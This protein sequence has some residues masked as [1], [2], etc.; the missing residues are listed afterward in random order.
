MGIPNNENMSSD[1][2]SQNILE[3]QKSFVKTIS[4]IW[5][6][7]RPNGGLRSPGVDAI[8]DFRHKVGKTSLPP[9]PGLTSSFL[10]PHLD[11]VKLSFP[12]SF[13]PLLFSGARILSLKRKSPLS[14]IHDLIYIL[15]NTPHSLCFQAKK[16]HNCTRPWI[17]FC[18][19]EMC[20]AQPLDSPRIQLYL[21]ENL[22]CSWFLIIFL[23]TVIY[24]S[25]DFYVFLSFKLHR[26][27]WVYI[28][29]DA[30]ISS[31]LW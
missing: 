31:L 12:Y 13:Q 28:H 21:R 23:T 30:C 10:S 25:L 1:C 6:H 19:L 27:V 22:H 29:T 5:G 15:L 20:L 2:F 16:S 9:S 18:C 26:C 4:E 3:T 24:F 11:C 14:S 8:S 7:F 17:W